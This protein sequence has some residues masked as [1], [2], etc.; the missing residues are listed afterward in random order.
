MSNVA[1]DAEL[2]VPSDLIYLRSVRTF[3][4]KLAESIGFCHERA[5]RI[6]LSVDEVF[7]NAVEHGSA[8]S[9]SKIAIHCLPTDKK[10]KVIVSDTGPGIDA[11]T[12]WPDI[13]TDLVREGSQPGTAR[14][15][16][17]LIAYLLTDK[18]SIESNS[19][20]GVDV[21]LVICK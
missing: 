8:G 6:E 3:V 18:M 20:G 15:H 12:G 2:R 4:R 1:C 16:G 17:L 9:C 19:M 5:N 7:S 11:N 10:I 13:W 14:G 21:H